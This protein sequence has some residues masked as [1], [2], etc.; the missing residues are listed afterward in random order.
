MG[1][2]KVMPLREVRDSLGK[3]VDAAHYG[4]EFTVITKAE[5]PRAVLVPYSWFIAIAGVENAT[6]S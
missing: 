1:H 2:R 5:E 4:Q 3:R 6:G